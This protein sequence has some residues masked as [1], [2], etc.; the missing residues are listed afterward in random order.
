MSSGGPR[1]FVRDSVTPL[2][3]ETAIEFKAHLCLC[4]E[5]LQ[6]WL[7]QPGSDR[8]SRA[9]VSRTLNAFLNTGTGG[10]V[11]L[12]ILDSGE[13]A[14]INMSQFK[15]DHVIVNLDDLMSR[16]DPPVEKHRY[17][18]RYVPVVAPDST[19]EE[20]QRTL[21]FDSRK[22]VDADERQRPHIV[23]SRQYCWCD[24]DTIAKCSTTSSIPMS[25]VVE[26]VVKQW[27]PTDERNL[28]AVGEMKTH[29]IHQDECGKVYFRR[30]ASVVQCTKQEIIEMS[31]NT[32]AEFYQPK[33]DALNA[34]V[35]R[36]RKLILE[37][38]SAKASG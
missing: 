8:R 17:K 22:G 30:Q 16:Y 29:P 6:L 18:I 1:Y 15:K 23:R 33:L 38:K 14:G 36:L 25:Y 27:D 4:E 32:V 31:K 5:E 35:L 11:Y 10:T 19:A 20:I 28:H 34:E 24:K 7:Y 26:I 3:E 2:E 9:P 37:K 21:A 12:G 13:V